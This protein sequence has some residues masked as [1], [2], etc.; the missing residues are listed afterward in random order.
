MTTEDSMIDD[1]QKPTTIL[2]ETQ[3]SRQKLEC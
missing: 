2:D 3:P 1:A